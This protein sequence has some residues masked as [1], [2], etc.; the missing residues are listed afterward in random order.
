MG[1]PLYG[2]NKDGINIQ[3]VV[4]L[5]RSD[6]IDPVEGKGLLAQKA[7][8]S[9]A[10]GNTDN[11]GVLINIGT[12]TSVWGG[13]VRVEGVGNDSGSLDFDLGL[14]AGQ[15]DF[16][17]G[18]GSSGDGV[19]A[20]KDTDFIDVSGAEDVH[21]SIDANSIDSSKTIKVTIC[22]LTAVAPASS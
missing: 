10:G 18:Y 8:Y 6:K 12:D 22:L 2:S 16:G 14:A 1:I 15:A 7:E 19:Y 17:A 9:F 20:L 13:F 5:F 21:L 11:S 4:D 3:D